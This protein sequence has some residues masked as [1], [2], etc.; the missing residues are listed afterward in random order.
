MD[1][2]AGCVTLRAIRKTAELDRV[3]RLMRFLGLRTALIVAGVAAVAAVPTAMVLGTKPVNSTTTLR[4][5]A[6]SKPH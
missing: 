3:N 5:S 1:S 6:N 2:P 4:P